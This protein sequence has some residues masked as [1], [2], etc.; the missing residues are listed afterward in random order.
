[1][2]LKIFITFAV[3]KLKRKQALL[4]SNLSAIDFLRCTVSVEAGRFV[5]VRF[6]M[7][8]GIATWL[9]KPNYNPQVS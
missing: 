3:R 4:G 2:F 6:F 8:T 1:L 5:F 7:D 9:R